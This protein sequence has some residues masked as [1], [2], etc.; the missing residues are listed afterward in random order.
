M[1]LSVSL[2]CLAGAAFVLS[3]L[4]GMILMIMCYGFKRSLG[5]NIIWT[6]LI[7]FVALLFLPILLYH[8][9]TMFFLTLFI[10]FAGLTLGCVFVIISLYQAWNMERQRSSRRKEE[11]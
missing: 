4:I 10:L 3:S 6:L 1:E 2:A 11:R 8:T 5:I 7:L 9:Y